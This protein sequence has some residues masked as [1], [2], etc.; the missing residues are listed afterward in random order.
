VG[1]KRAE[2]ISVASSYLQELAAERRSKATAKKDRQV[3]DTSLSRSEFLEDMDKVLSKVF[4]KPMVIPEVKLTRSKGK[5]KRVCNLFLSDSHCGANLD[6]KEVPVGYGLVEESRRVASVMLEAADFKRQY[7]SDTECYVHFTGDIIQGK[8][9][10]DNSLMWVIQMADALHIFVQA[11]AYLAQQFPNGV[12]IRC[13]PGN[14]GRNPHKNPK[15]ATDQ[16]YDGYETFLYYSLKKALAHIPNIRFEIPLTPYYTYDLFGQS[17]IFT[18]GDGGIVAGSPNSNIDVKKIRDKLNEW[19]SGE[20]QK[21]F[22]LFGVGHCHTGSVIHMNNGVIFMTNGTLSP[23]DP[24]G[25]SMGYSSIRCG[26]WIWES[27]PGYI[28]GDHRFC[29]IDKQTDQNKDMDRIV[30]PFTGLDD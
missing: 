23:T 29:F 8:L 5:T 28:V 11:F 14:H 18:H 16:K 9:H 4:A 27:T 25:I 1:T 10:P 21:R 17:A 26:Q 24:Y 7:R 13:T 3:V 19:N 15:R 22:T 30:R 2:K 6:P 20:L 12:T